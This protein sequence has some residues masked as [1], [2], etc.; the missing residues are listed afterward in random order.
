MRSSDRLGCVAHREKGT[1][2]NNHIVLLTA[3]ESRVLDG[4]KDRMLT[5]EIFAEFAAEYRREL[6][7]LHVSE[8]SKHETSATELGELETR[9]DRVV[10]AFAEGTASPTLKAKLSELEEQ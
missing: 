2:S 7:R 9:I 4:P 10:E 8:T 6:K 5:P 1:C 3:L